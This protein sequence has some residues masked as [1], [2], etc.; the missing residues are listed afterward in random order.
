[1]TPEKILNAAIEAVTGRAENHGSPGD[2]FA[3]IAARWGVTLGVPVTA[4]QVALCLIDMK[5]VRANNN[6]Q[7]IDNAI[8][9]AG[10][11]SLL[12]E[13]VPAA[14]AAEQPKATGNVTVPLVCDFLAR[15]LAK[16][17][18]VLIDNNG[19]TDI[20]FLYSATL[21]YPNKSNRATWSRAGWKY[22][23]SEGRRTSC[24][25]IRI[26]RD[27]VVVAEGQRYDD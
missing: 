9:I 10:Y 11:A 1:M 15:G 4:H 5:I 16:K 13:L 21:Y 18:D 26:E 24:H 17:G 8:D 14:P 3:D 6:P 27:G 22:V 2:T 20:Y 12:G 25:I 23:G 19:N 7:H